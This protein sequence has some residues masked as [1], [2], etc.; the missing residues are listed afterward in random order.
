MTPYRVV[1]ER[2][3]G[4]GSN[5]PYPPHPNFVEGFFLGHRA[6]E[7]D[8]RKECPEGMDEVAFNL[9]YEYAS[10]LTVRFADPLPKKRP[11][12]RNLLH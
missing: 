10:R 4:A 1:L 6:A 5:E 3:E 12:A 2:A 9:G 8:N 11:S 7:V